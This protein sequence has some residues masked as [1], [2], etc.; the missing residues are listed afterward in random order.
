MEIH[1]TEAYFAKPAAGHAYKLESSL[2][3]KNWLPYG[4][5]EDVILQ[6]PH[7]D[8]KTAVVRYL[9]ITVLKGTPGLWE[10]RVY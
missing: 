9:R 4:G 1:R 8:A 7:I 5:H 2:D 3:G 10:F 6:S